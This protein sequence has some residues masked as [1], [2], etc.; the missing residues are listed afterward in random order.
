MTRTKLLLVLCFLAAFA[1]GGAAGLVV[2]TDA[3]EP[4][5]GHASWL[6]EQLKLTPQQQEQMSKIWSGMDANSHQRFEQRRALAEER[7][8]AI[9]ALMTAEQK[10]KYE[11][12]LQDYDRKTAELSAERKLAFDQAVERTKKE[13]LTPE[14][15]KQYDEILK[16]QRDRGPGGPPGRRGGPPGGEGGPPPDM[17]GPGM[18]PSWPGGGFGRRGGP[19]SRPATE[20]SN[21]P[22]QAGAP[23][24]GE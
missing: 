16:H 9:T 7:D 4:P 18:P 12:I 11:Q 5:R 2:R 6:R 17:G 22:P 10:P 19:R 15:A 14:Q 13:V 20:E 21:L 24:V 1:A 23:L 3:K 8:K